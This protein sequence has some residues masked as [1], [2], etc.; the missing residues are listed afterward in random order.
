MLTHAQGAIKATVLFYVPREES[1]WE[2]EKLWRTAAA[3]PGVDVAAD[4]DGIW[5]KHFGAETS[6][7][8]VL[9][10][11]G[12]HLVFRGGI[13]GARGHEG[14]NAGQTAVV[15]LALTR[16]RSAES[17]AVFGCSLSTPALEFAQNP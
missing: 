2:K 14:D 6:G 13:T 8:V 5:A 10:D 4:P 7:H 12:G 17:T 9:F 1:G 15:N 3:I 11:R 16:H